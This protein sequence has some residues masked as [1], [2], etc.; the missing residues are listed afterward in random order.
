M[1]EPV[2]E[3]TTRKIAL[4]AYA[5]AQGGELVR[6]EREN[7]EFVIDSPWPLGEALKRFLASPERR[8]D[9]HVLR[10]RAIKRE[11]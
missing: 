4:A 2:T 8:F 7:G 3:W 11:P 6:Y 10:L 1:T 5:L 9:D